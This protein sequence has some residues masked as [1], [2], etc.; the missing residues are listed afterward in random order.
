MLAT[1][2]AFTADERGM[3]SVRSA[4]SLHLLSWEPLDLG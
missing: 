3:G 1:I 4:G 2:L